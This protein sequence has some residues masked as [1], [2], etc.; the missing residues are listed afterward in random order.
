MPVFA[1]PC[2]RV[3]SKNAMIGNMIAV[4]ALIGSQYSWT[5]HRR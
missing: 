5:T 4:K 1:K 3:I 2:N